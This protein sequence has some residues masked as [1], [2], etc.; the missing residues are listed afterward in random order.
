MVSFMGRLIWTSAHIKK[1]LQRVAIVKRL[2]PPLE[3]GGL[4]Q[5][6]DFGHISGFVRVIDHGAGNPCT[7]LCNFW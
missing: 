7:V 2:C 4:Q 3:L 6:E 1:T 5:C